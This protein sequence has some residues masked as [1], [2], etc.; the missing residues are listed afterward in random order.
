MPFFYRRET[1]PCFLTGSNPLPTEI[2]VAANA[3]ASSIT[4][5]FS[6]RTIGN[7]PD[8]S[9]STQSFSNIN[10]VSSST[11]LRFALDNFAT[12]TPLSAS[13]LRIL[14]QQ[15]EVYIA[16]E[17]GV[18]SEGGDLAIEVPKFF[19]AMQVARVKTALGIEIPGWEQSVE[20]LVDKVLETAKG[21]E[22]G[23]LDQV[24]GLGMV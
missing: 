23:L 20:Y 12:A 2:Q 1:T 13:S 19:L 16:T 4:C 7:V 5:D 15:L 24:V 21:E 17:A 22:R 10:F 8:V 14:E 18:R 3:F 6:R 9:T 11:P